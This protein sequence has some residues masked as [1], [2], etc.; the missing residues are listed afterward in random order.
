M[1]T[2]LLRVE[3]LSVSID[4]AE[5]EIRPLDQVSFEL[6]EGETF[7]LLGESGCGKS[8]TALSLMRLLPEG[9]RITR[10]SI[11]LQDRDLCTVT[12]AEMRAIRGGAIAMIFQ[13]PGTSL[14]PVLT[15]GTQL[16]EVLGVHRQRSTYRGGTLIACR[17]HSRCRAPSRRISHAAL[18]RH[19]TARDDCHGPSGRA[20]P[21]DR[22]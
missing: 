18:R 5:S 15:I 16:N 22:R 4:T 2:P 7:V 17:W 12:E 1:S 10:G 11:H 20:T 8:M 6:N 9:G 21:A 13:E 3:A 19:E 14:N